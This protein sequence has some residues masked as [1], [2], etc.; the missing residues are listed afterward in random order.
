MIRRRFAI[1]LFAAAWWRPAAA[2]EPATVSVVVKGGKPVDGP[3]VVKLKRDD[4]VV[5]QVVT[6]T[7]D[8]LH[9]HGYNL[10]LKLQPNV[11]ATLKF[12]AR[13]TGRFSFELHKAGTELGVFEIYPQ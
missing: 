7:A 9:L 3:S 13:R 6:D 2:G 12:V 5:L 10:H 1:T 11:P 4:A 8:E